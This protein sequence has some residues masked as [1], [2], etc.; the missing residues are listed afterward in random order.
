MLPQWSQE[1]LLACLDAASTKESLSSQGRMECLH[2]LLR[3]GN[4]TDQDNEEFVG[5]WKTAEAELMK[6]LS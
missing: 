5:K 4:A 2:S 6:L 3:R 1:S